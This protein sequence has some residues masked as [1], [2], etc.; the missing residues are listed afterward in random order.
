MVVTAPGGFE[1]FRF[2]VQVSSPPQVKSASP[3]NVY[4]LA[5]GT[6]KLETEFEGRL[7][8]RVSCSLLFNFQRCFKSVHN[9]DEIKIWKYYIWLASVLQ[10]PLS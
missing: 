7:T 6:V 2:E 5:G 8:S 1:T 3:A 4:V 10:L 9:L